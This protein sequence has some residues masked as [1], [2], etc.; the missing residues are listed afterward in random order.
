L[1]STKPPSAQDASS[2]KSAAAAAASHSYA[3]TLLLP[4]TKFAEFPTAAEEQ[5]ILKHCN[6]TIY[7]WNQKV[8]LSAESS[9]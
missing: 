2:K 3:D 6:D 9:I 7:D 8:E 4:L 1:R 5:R